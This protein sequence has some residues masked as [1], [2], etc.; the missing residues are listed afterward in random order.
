MRQWL[1][2]FRPKIETIGWV[3]T[4]GGLTVPPLLIVCY[5]F[6]TSFCAIVSS[7]I[8]R[9][10]SGTT[11]AF[12]SLVRRGHGRGQGL[13]VAAVGA[14]E[15]RGGLGGKLDGLGAGAGLDRSDEVNF[16][17]GVAIVNP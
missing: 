10:V 7:R 1:R 4:G 11:R 12:S 17:L 15:D 2:E 5:G 14:F 13:D 8:S 9:T 6:Q 16:A 3:V